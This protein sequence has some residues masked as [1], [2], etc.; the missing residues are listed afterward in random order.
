MAGVAVKL[1]TDETFAK[2]VREGFEQSKKAEAE[3]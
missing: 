3:E 2:E 1:L